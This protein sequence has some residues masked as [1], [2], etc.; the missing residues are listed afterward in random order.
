MIEI[1][2]LVTNFEHVRTNELFAKSAEEHAAVARYVLIISYFI[3]IVVFLLILLVHTCAQHVH[4]TQY[5][6]LAA[7]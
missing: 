6:W 2:T 1:E 4:Y 7:S 5:R 3:I